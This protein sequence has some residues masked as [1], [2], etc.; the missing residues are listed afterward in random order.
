MFAQH[1]PS[2]RP[3]FLELNSRHPFLF[4]ASFC[5]VFSRSSWKMLAPLA[6]LGLAGC[7][8]KTPTSSD[9]VQAPPEIVPVA[10]KNP[11]IKTP[12]N[13][14]RVEDVPD[15]FVSK[16]GLSVPKGFDVQLLAENLFVPRRLAIAPGATPNRYDLFVSESK[17]NRVSVLQVRG[18]KVAR[19]SAFTSDA[20]Q[21]YGL[22]FGKG[23]LY[24]GNTDAVVR[25]PYTTGDT[26][27]SGKAQKIAD[28]TEGGYNQHW[29]RNLLFDQSGQKL[30]VTV[31]SSCNTCEE[32]DSQRAAISVMNPD[33]SGRRLFATG[34]RNPVGLAWQPGTS[35][36][37]TVCNERDNLGDDIPPDYLT[38]VRDGAFYGWPYAYTD[39]NRR[40][41]PDPTFGA[42]APDKVKATRAPTVPVQAHSAALGVAFYPAKGGNF[43]AEFRGDA[44]LTFHGSWNRSAKT[45]Y[46]VVRVDF[47]EGQPAKITDF[48][49][50]FLYQGKEWGRPVDVQIA[51]DGSLLFSDDGGGKIWRVVYKGEGVPGS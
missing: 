31:G 4:R 46:K 2:L 28:L 21:P 50:G 38:L 49:Q 19:K 34:I 18:G 22:A 40:V 20:N 13:I 35:N 15:R 36:L 43:P 23:F 45:G 47:E 32:D 48:V 26:K 44:F 41:F 11:T 42:K 29:T 25:F 3:P 6:A 30:F 1:N 17:A 37:W 24:V 27:A 5:A 16:S 14:V 10:T 33:G 39:I 8:A 51:P 7:N 12:K 9:G